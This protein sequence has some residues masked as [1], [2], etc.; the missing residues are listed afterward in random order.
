MSVFKLVR[1]SEAHKMHLISKDFSLTWASSFALIQLWI[2][3]IN[4]A[5]DGLFK[6]LR[7]KPR[8]HNIDITPLGARI[9]PPPLPPRAPCSRD[10]LVMPTLENLFINH[11]QHRV[12]FAELSSKHSS[13]FDHLIE[14]R[15]IE[16]VGFHLRGIIPD[17]ISQITVHSCVHKL[18]WIANDRVKVSF[19]R[20][21][22]ISKVHEKGTG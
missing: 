17:H 2:P 1:I 22:C 8:L 16:E 18:W 6:L 9:H 3:V 19:F 12:T 11:V 21:H 15:D 13:T 4:K 14:I 7:L 10:S 5:C 20:Q